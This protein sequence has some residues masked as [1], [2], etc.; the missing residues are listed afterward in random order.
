[1]VA[2]MATRIAFARYL[3]EELLGL[4]SLYTSVLQILQITEL[5]IG[6]AM[7]IFLYEPVKNSDKEKT[8]AL[9]HLYKN[10]YNVFAGILLLL[11]IGVQ[12]LLIPHIV[13]VNTIAMKTVQ[14]VFLPV[15]GWNCMQL[16]I[17][18]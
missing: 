2:T 15:L 14:S 13:D 18:I 10:V 17:C 9:I 1:M 11:G 12:V 4:N 8:K 16:F 3:G 6:N 7:I 5:G